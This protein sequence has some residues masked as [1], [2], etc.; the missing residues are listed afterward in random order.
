GHVFPAGWQRDR[1]Q[2]D[3]RD[4]GDQ[5]ESAAHVV[6]NDTVDD[7]EAD[8]FT[9]RQD[10][11]RAPQHDPEPA[12]DAQLLGPGEGPVEDVAGNDLNDEAGEHGRYQDDRDVLCAPV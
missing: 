8:L 12:Q 11:G 5:R 10:E 1:I 9:V 7:V 4:P 6:G 3:Q 2:H